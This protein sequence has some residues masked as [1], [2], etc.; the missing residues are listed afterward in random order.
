MR[1]VNANTSALKS[2]AYLTSFLSMVT[3]VLST[4]GASTP[5]PGSG[6]GYWRV[7]NCTQ[8]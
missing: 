1:H 4:D 6:G 3:N 2:H 8:A 7:S 5:V